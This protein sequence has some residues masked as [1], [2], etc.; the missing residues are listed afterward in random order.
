MQNSNEDMVQNRREVL[1][2]IDSIDWT[3]VQEAQIIS[4]APVIYYRIMEGECDCGESRRDCRC[5][6]L[7]VEIVNPK[8]RWR[9]LWRQRQ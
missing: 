7:L 4:K 3:E 1:D 2:Y 9:Q 8:R 5:D 6:F